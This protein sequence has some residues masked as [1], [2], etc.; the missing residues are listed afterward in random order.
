LSHFDAL[1]TADSS[2]FRLQ[3]VR[4]CTVRGLSSFGDFS[5]SYVGRRPVNSRVTKTDLTRAT[6]S[7]NFELQRIEQRIIRKKSCA[8]VERS[9]DTPRH[10]CNF[11]TEHEL[12][13]KVARVT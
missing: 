11:V 9:S 1:F 10:T 12:R 7:R 2:D 8:T 6:L 4:D 3:V 13:N 5:A